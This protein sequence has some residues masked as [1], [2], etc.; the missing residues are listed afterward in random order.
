MAS[1]DSF[2]LLLL[3]LSRRGWFESLLLFKYGKSLRQ[4]GRFPVGQRQ[5][6]RCTTHKKR[7]FDGEPAANFPVILD[8]GSLV[9]Q[10]HVQEHCLYTTGTGTTLQTRTCFLVELLRRAIV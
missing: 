2:P 4:E 6:S 1:T 10:T 8:A 7:S 3:S 5:D 9:T